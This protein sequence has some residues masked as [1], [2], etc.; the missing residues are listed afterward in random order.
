MPVSPAIFSRSSFLVRVSR[1]M[2]QLMVGRNAS[3]CPEP[4]DLSVFLVTPVLVVG[5]NG[6]ATNVIKGFVIGRMYL[7]A[8]AEILVSR[9]P[10]SHTSEVVYNNVRG[11]G[12]AW[13]LPVV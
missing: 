12:C 6:Q 9:L 8:A 2:P 10:S 5:A 11:S 13:G 1:V 7:I 3:L 4:Q